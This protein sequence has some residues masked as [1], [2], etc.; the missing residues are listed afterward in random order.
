MAAVAARGFRLLREAISRNG[1]GVE[2]DGF[3]RLQAA[4]R[5][6][7]RFAISRPELFR[8]MFSGR[9][10]DRAGYRDLQEE[11]NLA[12]EALEKMIVGATGGSDGPSQIAAAARAAWALVH[13]I[14][15]LIVDGRIDTP[16]NNDPVES[17]EQLTVEVMAVL[18]R[19]L[20]SL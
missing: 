3:R 8:L 17:A 10:R 14:A 5:A 13:G 18:G 9:W 11:E 7:V 4:G 6:Y 12:F 19:G 16:P 2:T 1:S 15:T 20:R